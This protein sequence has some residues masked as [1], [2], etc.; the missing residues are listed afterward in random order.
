MPKTLCITR[1]LG[2][3]ALLVVTATA[4][5]EL[6]PR[7]TLAPHELRTSVA[8]A[9]IVWPTPPMPDGPIEFESAEQRHLRLVV[10]TKALE[11]PWSIAFLPDGSSL[12]TE[13]AGRLRI[14]RNGVLDPRPVPGIPAVKTG[15]E[16]GVQGLMDVVLHPRFSENHWVYFTYHKPAP[17]GDGATTLGRGTWNGSALTDVR[18]IFESGAT[19]TEA[20]RLVFARDGT[21]YMTISAPGSGPEIGRSQDPGDYAGKV[22]RLYDDGRIPRDNPFIGRAGHAPAIFTL[23]H[24]NGH[25]LALHPDTGEVWQTE[26]GPSG[27]D[28]VNII[29]P[30]NNYG[31]PIVSY[32]RDYF[33]PKI[34]VSPLRT[35]FEDPIVVWLPSIGL[36]GM[37]FYT[38]DRFPNWKRN[39]FVAGLREG[40][41]PRTGQIQRIEFS[42]KWQELRREPM[43]ADLKQRI[44]DVRQGPDGFLYVLT[45]EDQGALFR[46]EPG[47]EKPPTTG[48]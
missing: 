25:A 1:Y 12:V 3:F 27:G 22:V 37:T 2:C 5:A 35:G 31:W 11:Q 32:G 45:A 21:I 47:A 7:Q 9:A 44:R 23:G 20:S 36:T 29:R 30:G 48:K 4:T 15:G 33:G 28:E 46:I 13:R 8:P 10:V 38:G 19:G 6:P 43:L 39:V 17:N 34:S 41:I 16:G 14:I 26:Q 24:R 40:G 18:D 42:E